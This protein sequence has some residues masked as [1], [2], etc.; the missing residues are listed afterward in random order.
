MVEITDQMPRPAPGQAPL[1]PASEPER[2][3]A[4][5]RY[6]IL[7][8]PPDHSFDR[9]TAIAAKHF[10]VPISIVSIVDSDRI[11]FKSAHGLDGVS[12]I[13]RD[14]GLCASAILQDGEW[15]IEN[16]PK[17]ARALA[18]PLVAGEFGLR[19]YAGAPLRT[20]DG[21]NLGTLCVIDRE[22]RN[23]STD[24]AAVLRDMA[25]I[26]V[27]EL[28]LRLSAR[29]TAARERALRAQAERDAKILEQSLLPPELPSLT[30][31]DLAAKE[32]PGAAGAGGFFD[33][34]ALP[35]EDAIALVVG[36]VVG[37]GD[38]VSAAVGAALARYTIRTS[39][40]TA[41]GPAETLEALHRVL[42]HGD[43]DAGSRCAAFVVFAAR[44]G[45]AI[46]LTAASAGAAPAVILR[47]DGSTDTIAP[48]GILAGWQPDVAFDQ[49]SATLDRGDMLLL[50]TEERQAPPHKDAA[51]LV[52]GNSSRC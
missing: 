28:E 25:A 45:E 44:A 39:A 9:L 17:D 19:F 26:V 14:P 27:D 48:A 43:A 10:G 8:T 24:E 4:V 50:G 46:E 12:E 34:L 29:R 32:L 3:A 49:V 51:V 36:D 1:I 7:D 42:P 23:F 13:G 37:D 30:G 18:N 31:F 33:S 2:I 52:L 15:V 22:P 5:R 6:E 20:Q 38:D 41:S 16:A 11:W 21:H 40:Q 35:G 47:A